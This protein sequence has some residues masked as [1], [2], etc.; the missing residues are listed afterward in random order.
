MASAAGNPCHYNNHRLHSLGGGLFV[1][2]RK[3]SV[4]ILTGKHTPLE[5]TSLPKV[6]QGDMVVKEC[7]F[8]FP[9]FDIDGIQIIP[10]RSPLT[11]CLGRVFVFYAQSF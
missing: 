4:K 10:S 2:G 11:I 3:L 5:L 8:F 7:F 6:I 9:Q 1:C